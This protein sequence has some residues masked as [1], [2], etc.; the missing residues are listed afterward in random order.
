MSDRY[1]KENFERLKKFYSAYPIKFVEENDYI[2]VEENWFLSNNNEIKEHLK[3]KYKMKYND[4]LRWYIGA[5]GIKFLSEKPIKEEPTKSIEDL[6]KKLMVF[7]NRIEEEALKKSIQELLDANPYFYECPAALYYHHDY[8]GGLLEHSIQTLEL[9]FLTLINL[10]KIMEFSVINSDLIIAGALLHDIGKI[11]CYK[12]S[13]GFILPTNILNEQN[14]IISGVALVSKYI[15]S[16]QLDDLIHI[17]TSH[18][19]TKEWGS[20]IEPKSHEAWIIH[21]QENLSSKI[22]G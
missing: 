18:H 11:R 21:T 4:K 14:H 1:Y 5:E 7:I 6:K 10:E 8:K 16:K 19:A 12:M 9:A 22:A 3:Q 20:P 2:K 15:K 13:D 17:I